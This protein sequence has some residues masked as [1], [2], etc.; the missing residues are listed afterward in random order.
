M[1]HAIQETKRALELW[2]DN[3]RDD[4]SYMSVVSQMRGTSAA[5][6]IRSVLR[7]SK[8]D[9]DAD[10]GSFVPL[11]SPQRDKLQVC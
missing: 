7:D 9:G 10:L 1:L 3:K 11:P 2:C 5:S 4:L 6:L 8:M